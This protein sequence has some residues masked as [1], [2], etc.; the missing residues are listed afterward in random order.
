MF[1][2]KAKCADSVYYN[3]RIHTLDPKLKSAEALAI[4]AGKVVALGDSQWVR[5]VAA[6]GCEKHDLGGRTVL[7]GFIDCHTHFIQM[8]VDSL[9]TD[10]SGTKSLEDAMRLMAKASR[11]TPDGEWVIASSWKESGWR[12]G[13][14]INRDDLDKCCP[15]HPAVAHRVCG[16]LSSV[17]S[18][19]IALLNIDGKESGVDKDSSGRLT[20][21]LK[22][23]AI[24]RVHSATRPSRQKKMKGLL[25]AI[26]KA[27]SLGVTSI[28]DNG[29]VSDL[30][31]YG[32]AGRRGK[33]SVRV[34]FNIPSSDLDCVRSLS[35]PTGLGSEFFRIG[36]IKVFCDGA[37]G[38]RSAALSEP[39]ADDQANSGMFVH[40][41]QEFYEII[42]KA[43]ESGLQLAIHAI[44]DMGIERAIDALDRA[45]GES[46]RRNHRHRLE[47]L[48]LPSRRHLARMRKLSVV[49]SMQPNFIGEWGGTE[50]M[51][52]SRLGAVRTARNNPFREVIDSGVRLVFG[53]DCMPFSPI[54]GIHSA[55]N[56]PFPSQRI[57]PQEAMCAY[58]RDGAYASFAEQEWG[59]LSVGK[60]ADFVVL[61]GDPFALPHGI[62]T[63]KAMMTVV[64][65]ECVYA[66]RDTGHK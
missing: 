25:I 64:G 34:W 32:E 17:N 31:T 39:Y 47:H 50:G 51:Y 9:H 33:L 15:D 7:P 62:G 19:A 60:Q 3:A 30:E 63:I 37:L 29:S 56:A 58:T 1:H 57:T 22:E 10:L 41:E 48:E 55:V 27:H 54:Y 38:A 52:R 61:G 46:P 53:S 8:G 43:H 6:R 2:S 35:L 14:F 12:D 65:G 49:A 23:H 11:N 66:S 20:G 59:S 16:H 45:L 36:G 4:E 21:I 28:H 18:K 13:R 26:R 42:S 44:G 5:N 24:A 40:E